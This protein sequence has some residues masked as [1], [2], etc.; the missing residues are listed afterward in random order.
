MRRRVSRS[1][2]QALQGVQVDYF[3][4][5]SS[6]VSCDLSISLVNLYVSFVRV[7]CAFMAKSG[8]S[9]GM[10]FQLKANIFLEKFALEMNKMF[11]VD[12]WFPTDTYSVLSPG[13][14]V[15]RLNSALRD[16]E[17]RFDS[18]VERGS[19][20]VVKKVLQFCLTVNSFKLFKGGCKKG[21][22]LL[23][24]LRMTQSCITIDSP[25]NSD[26]DSCFLNCLVA[27]I[28]RVPRNPS[29]WCAQYSVIEQLLLHCWP[30]KCSFPV[31]S[32][33]WKSI[34]RH[35]PVSVNIYGY[36]KG[37]IFPVFLST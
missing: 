13:V 20:W 36:E 17:P 23:G 4:Y 37:V 6:R 21:S 2:R 34:D 15:D 16:V 28:A 29:Q 3:F 12:V 25:P 7:L 32:R 22:F 8:W 14:L 30:N 19:G 27:G 9:K 10:K 5:P 26:S 18:F 31:T 35:C 1:S 11:Q 33:D 24:R